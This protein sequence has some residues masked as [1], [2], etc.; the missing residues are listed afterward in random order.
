MNP[1]NGAP[2]SAAKLKWPF[3][4]GSVVSTTEPFSCLCREQTSKPL[5]VDRSAK[6][7]QKYAPR[8]RNKIV[9]FWDRRPIT[10]S[11]IDDG[12]LVPKAE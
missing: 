2:N 11:V 5:L 3:L 4:T 12:Y 10:R 8:C 6:R 9:V 7:H 1:R